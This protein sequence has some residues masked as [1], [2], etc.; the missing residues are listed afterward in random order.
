MNRL[1]I[2]RF[3]KKP[4]GEESIGDF[5]GHVGLINVYIIIDFSDQI[6]T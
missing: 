4:L 6:L 5:Y 3:R 2:I 1:K